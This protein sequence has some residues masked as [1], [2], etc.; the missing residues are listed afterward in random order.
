L[1]FGIIVVVNLHGNHN[2]VCDDDDDEDDVYV[3]DDEIKS[4]D[5]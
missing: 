3:V 1:F 4:A 2:G 5:E